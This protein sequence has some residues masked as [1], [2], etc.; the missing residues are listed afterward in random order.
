MAGKMCGV[1]EMSFGSTEQAAAYDGL[2]DPQFTHGAELLSLLEIG[3][4]E[5]VLDIGCGTGRLAVAALEHVGT[6][7]RVVGIDPAPPRIALAR[8][9]ADPRFDFRVGRAEDLSEF[10]DATFDVAYLNSVLNWIRDRGQAL[11]EAHRVLK[12]GGR[13]GIGTTVRDRPNQLWLLR[14]R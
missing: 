12:P 8:E 9:R 4:D 10:P 13:L 3:H 2:S 7:G 14:R 6:E 5:R 1:S 11:R